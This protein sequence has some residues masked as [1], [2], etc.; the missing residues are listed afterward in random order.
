M[1]EFLSHR[2]FSNAQRLKGISKPQFFCIPKC[3]NLEIHQILPSK[4]GI[5]DEFS[6]IPRLTENPSELLWKKRAVRESNCPKS[7]IIFFRE[8]KGPETSFGFGSKFQIHAYRIQEFLHMCWDLY[9][10]IMRD[11]YVIWTTYLFF[12]DHTPSLILLLQMGHTNWFVFTFTKKKKLICI[13]YSCQIKEPSP[14]NFDHWGPV[15]A[16]MCC[17]VEGK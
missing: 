6:K 8:K 15:A 3:Q 12:L 7:L 1:L 2:V 10:H 4:Q 13:Y 16:I 9:G 17:T 5:S 14:L 11:M